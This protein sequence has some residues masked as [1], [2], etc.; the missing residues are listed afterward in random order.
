MLEAQTAAAPTAVAPTAAAPTAGMERRQQR[1]AGRHERRDERRTGRTERREERR[2]GT[3]T[4]AATTTGTGRTPAQLSNSTGTAKSLIEPI[5]RN[6]GRRPSLRLERYTAEH[7]VSA[8]R[9]VVVGAQSLE[10]QMSKRKPASKHARSPKIAAKA[11]RAKQAIVRSPK[12][13]RAA[14]STK[15]PPERHNNSKQ[16][17]PLVVRIRRQQPYKMTANND[18]GTIRKKGFEFFFSHGKGA[19]FSSKAAGNDASQHATSF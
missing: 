15:S 16:E 7:V 1:R 3:T 6:G 19:G 12:H 14:S 17:T 9:T 10:C 5:A 4:G 13:S 2:T 18:D 11:H 8:Q